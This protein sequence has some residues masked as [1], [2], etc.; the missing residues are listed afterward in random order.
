MR[1]KL[2]TLAAGVSAVLCVGVCVLWVRSYRVNDVDG[3]YVN[4]WDGLA[5]KTRAWGINS[6]SGGLAFFALNRSFSPGPDPVK[7]IELKVDN[8][9]LSKP[10]FSQ[11]PSYGYP[12]MW[13]YRGWGRFG[14]GLF[15]GDRPSYGEYERTV[16]NDH[17]MVLPDWFVA[18]MCAML[19]VWRV[20]SGVRR[21]RVA[22]RRRA[23][24][25]PACGYDLRATAR[26]LPGMRGR[27]PRRRGSGHEAQA[28]HARGG[29]IGGA[30][31]GT[32][33][34]LGGDLSHGAP[35]LL[36]GRRRARFEASMVRIRLVG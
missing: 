9:E 12:Y 32:G 1:R 34:G 5:G 25:C 16:R 17:F 27:P 11:E 4:H 7:A 33:G 18:L 20:A 19:P 22:A 24:C 36:D 30:V 15:W 29:G 8:P 26:P 2:F 23:G 31:L 13:D 14:F 6:D 35:G 28:L 10:G 21:R 3:W